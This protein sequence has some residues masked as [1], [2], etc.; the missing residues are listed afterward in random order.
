MIVAR[1]EDELCVLR[2]FAEDLRQDE[3]D[4]LSGMDAVLVHVYLFHVVSPFSRDS[5][6]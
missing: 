4:I 6:L 1:L 5:Y 2:V 3:R